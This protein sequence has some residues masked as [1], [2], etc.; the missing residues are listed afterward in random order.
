[1]RS[2]VINFLGRS[3]GTSPEATAKVADHLC[4]RDVRGED[5]VSGAGDSETDVTDRPHEATH[6]RGNGATGK[7]PIWGLG[8]ASLFIVSSFLLFGL[9]KKKTGQVF[10][11]GL[12]FYSAPLRTILVGFGLLLFGVTLG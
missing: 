6:D 5:A 10:L 1:M 12:R 11:A 4:L 3:R 7:R 8:L 2:E 9:S